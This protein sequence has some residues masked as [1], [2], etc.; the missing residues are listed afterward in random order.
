VHGERGA[1]ARLG[2]DRRDRR[3][4]EPDVQAVD[5]HQ[6][7]HHVEGVRRDKDHQRR[8]HVGHPAQVA[9]A[10]QRDQREWQAGRGDPQVVHGQLLGASLRAHQRDQGAGRG[11]QHQG[12]GHADAGGQPQRLR[13]QRPGTRRLSRARQPRHLGGRAIG[14]KVE[15]REA[16]REQGARDRERGELGRTQVP[17]H[18][19]VGEEI[20]GLGRESAERRHRQ[21]DDLPVVCGA[22]LHSRTK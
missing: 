8:A 3:A 12:E 19:R 11:R 16:A 13:R 22:E 2:D 10:G 1:H 9:L 6:P 14:Q 18:R 7:E 17:D 4:Q 20:E 5:Q 21:A 15:Q